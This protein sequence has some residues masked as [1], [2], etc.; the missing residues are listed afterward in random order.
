[1]SFNNRISIRDTF[2]SRGGA[3]DYNVVTPPDSAR[4]E[5][6]MAVMLTETEKQQ[7]PPMRDQ[8]S[9]AD[10]DVRVISESRDLILAVFLI[11]LRS[12]LVGRHDF[13][14]ATNLI[15]VF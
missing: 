6:A 1:M 13:G 15:C 12:P 7:K 5:S 10:A 2:G 9:E 14:F 8:L 4:S 3:V 11:V